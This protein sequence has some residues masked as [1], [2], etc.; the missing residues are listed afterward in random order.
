MECINT[1]VN[2][3]MCWEDLCSKGR[4]GMHRGVCVS[5]MHSAGFPG[6]QT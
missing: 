4:R 5:L 3:H 1:S 6:A 2:L